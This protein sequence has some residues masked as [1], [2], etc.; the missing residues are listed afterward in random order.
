MSAARVGAKEQLYRR[1]SV[2]KRSI[3]SRSQQSCAC[4]RASYHK[5]YLPSHP[6]PDCRTVNAYDDSGVTNNTC[7]QLLASGTLTCVDFAVGGRYVGYCNLECGV[8][9]Y[10]ANPE[11]HK[12]CTAILEGLVPDQPAVDTCTCKSSMSVLC[13]GLP[14]LR[15]AECK[16][17]LC[18]ALYAP[19]G[20][21]VVLSKGDKP[22]HLVGYCDFECNLCSS[23]SAMC[24]ST[25][26]DGY[27]VE[28]ALAD[29]AQN[30]TPFTVPLLPRRLPGSFMRS[31]SR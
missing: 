8:N 2:S 6:C 18:A 12:A 4:G 3:C 15:L 20:T 25:A 19:N 27:F 1:Q 23:T 24:D 11:T 29:P 17:H 21:G 7:Q 9:W 26:P 22:S 16:Q 5:L 10:D 30:C 14:Q 13:A 31:S 28:P